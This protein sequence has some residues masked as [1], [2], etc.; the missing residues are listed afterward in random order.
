[1]GF[2]Y[3]AKPVAKKLKNFAKSLADKIK[4][5]TEV[6]APTIGALPKAEPKM[7]AS[8]R[9][10]PPGGGNVMTNPRKLDEFGFYYKSEELANKMKQTKGSGK[11]FENF[12]KGQGVTETEL[13][14]TGLDDLFKVTSRPITKKDILT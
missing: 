13:F 14:D 1:M 3:L 2:A 5:D 8:T 10:M 4:G 11:D 9:R 6:S 12:F 7:L